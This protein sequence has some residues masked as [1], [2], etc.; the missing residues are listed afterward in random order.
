MKDNKPLCVRDAVQIAR[1]ILAVRASP[2]GSHAPIGCSARSG[3]VP[4]H[5]QLGREALLLA[6]SGQRPGRL[7][8]I[9]HAQYRPPSQSP[10]APEVAWCGADTGAQGW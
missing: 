3:D 1:C 10:G 8:D 4:G 9:P 7:Q 2:Q 6:S 5:Q